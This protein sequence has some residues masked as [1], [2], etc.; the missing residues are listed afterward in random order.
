M[1]E[2]WSGESSFSIT[3]VVS[4]CCSG[5]LLVVVCG[6]GVGVGS[7]EVDELDVVEVAVEDVAKNNEDEDHN[8]NILQDHN[9][10]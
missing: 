2:P 7:S 5:V 8:N 10:C 6:S 3:V 4:G 1:E 9:K